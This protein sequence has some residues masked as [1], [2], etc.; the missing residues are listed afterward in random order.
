MFPF[1]NMAPNAR[2]LPIHHKYIVSLGMWLDRKIWRILMNLF[3]FI[4]K[5][6]KRESHL[7]DHIL[8]R[9]VNVINAAVRQ[10]T[11]LIMTWELFYGLFNV[12]PFSFLIMLLI[13]CQTLDIFTKCLVTSLFCMMNV[14]LICD[15]LTT[16]ILLHF[17]LLLN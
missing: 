6:K 16:T 11:T 9:Y 2:G 4:F 5:T 7:E 8:R 13:H 10:Y 14:G 12:C 3:Y 1:V 15:T 17:W